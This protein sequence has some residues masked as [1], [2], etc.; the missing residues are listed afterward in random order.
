VLVQQERIARVRALCGRDARDERI[1]A[2]RMYG[3]TGRRASHE[4]YRAVT[5]RSPAADL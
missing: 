4:S 3:A 1:E 5:A 2:P